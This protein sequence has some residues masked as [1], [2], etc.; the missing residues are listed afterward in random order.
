MTDAA[1][2]APMTALPR[3]V[4]MVPGWAREPLAF[5]HT[6]FSFPL[7]DWGVAAL[8]FAGALTLD[9][10][11][12]SWASLWFDETY[13]IG[14]AS[15]PLHI[16]FRYIWSREPNMQLYY[17][18]L[19]VWLTLTAKLGLHPTEAVA[20]FPSAIFAALSSV[21]VYLL[22]RRFLGWTAGAVAATL[23]SLSV[24]TLT[25]AQQARSYSLELLLVIAAWYMLFGALSER[26]QRATRWWW[27]LYTLVTA[28]A[29]YAHLFAFF[30]VVAQFAG[31]ALILA[32]PGPW[33]ERAREAIRPALTSLGVVT[34]LILP[35]IYAASHG[36]HISWVPPA[37]PADVRDLLL[38]D[39][40]GGD[41]SYLYV[42]LT[43]IALGVMLAAAA[44]L[45]PPTGGSGRLRAVEP[46]AA[47]LLCWLVIPFALSYAVTQPYLN[48][49]FFYARYEVVI[50]PAICLL[51][52][53]GVQLLPI[54][55]LQIA[56]T[57]A[58]LVLA[59]ASAPYYY[60]HAQIQD[61][62]DPI[63]WLQTQYQP[64]DGIV[65]VPNDLCSIPTQAYL[66]AYPGA[67]RFDADSPGSYS[68]AKGYAIPVTL[69]R[70]KAYAARHS[71]IFYIVAT[72][73]GANRDASAD[74]AARQWLAAN[75][76]LRGKASVSGLVVYYYTRA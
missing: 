46:G 61:F 53:L 67:A 30:V 47:L 44:R 63:A 6:R 51:A 34:V 31:L 45:R 25:S 73:G 65:C 39:V 57:S 60:A 19:H 40:S 8:V 13:S 32:L 21:A 56:V 55:T 52:G 10:R 66:T 20:R 11:Q 26:D 5:A 42:L 17:L 68:W 12:L 1:D 50:I 15:Q 4:L 16:M 29:L 62:R 76:S 58:L 69:A 27:A 49:H 54:R 9:L 18:I 64:G 59:S 74:A 37:T 36:S 22:G 72:L 7:V 48:L 2:R 75:Y 24:Y 35:L 70:V 33:R 71:R 14:L 43:L 28:L 38:N 23:Y 41:P 3:S